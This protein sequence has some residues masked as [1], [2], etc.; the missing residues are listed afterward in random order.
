MAYA[1][2]GTWEMAM[3]GMSVAH[4]MMAGGAPVERAVEEAIALVEANPNFDSVGYGGLP[5]R[6]GE[7]E[8]DAAY[9][10]GGT[11][12]FGAVM[13]VRRIQSPIRVARSLV[14]RRTDCL[15]CGPGAEHYAR[16][17]GFAERDMRTEPSQARWAEEKRRLEGGGERNDTEQRYWGHDTVC[18]IGLDEQGRMGVGVSTSGLFMKQPGRIGDSPIIGSGFYCDSEVG[19]AAATGL[20]EFIMRGCLSFEIVRAMRDGLTPQEACE[21][22]AREHMRSQRRRGQPIEEFAVIALDAQGRFGA[23]GSVLSFPYVTFN[24]AQAPALNRVDGIVLPE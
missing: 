9:M 18:M 15:L 1:M 3:E 5:N 13:G 6:E 16:E 10:D 12:S 4:P 14:G 7:V 20:G 24:S 23:A 22:A 19:G 11:L 17:A 2:I 8:L 21:R